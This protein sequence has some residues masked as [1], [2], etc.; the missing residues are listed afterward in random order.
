MTGEL[1][2][3]LQIA[4]VGFV[5]N[6]L[7]PHRKGQNPFEAAAVGLPIVVGPNSE[8]FHGDYESLLESGGGLKGEDLM[9]T[10]DAIIQLI[11]KRNVRE[12]IGFEAREWFERKSADSEVIIRNIEEILSTRVL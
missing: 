10:R 12:Q 9:S 7:L 5:G 8:D 4:D 3:F 11:K 2:R 1:A 6:S